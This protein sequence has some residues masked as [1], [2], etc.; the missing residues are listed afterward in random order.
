LLLL[1]SLVGRA[2]AWVG[3]L[4]EEANAQE[5]V[6]AACKTTL[7]SQ[8]EAAQEIQCVKE[9]MA[10]QAQKEVAALKKKLEVA[11]QK[12]KDV[13]ANLQDIIEGMLP[14]SPKVDSAYSVS[15]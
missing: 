1:Q 5:E 10:R 12:A 3:L 13:A 11:E 4:W 2:Q 7:Q 14:R 8:I 9:A 6:A 15:C